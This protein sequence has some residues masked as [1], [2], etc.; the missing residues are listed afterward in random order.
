MLED[1]IGQDYMVDALTFR[2]Q[3]IS[4]FDDYKGLKY[5][6]IKE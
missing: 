4:M 3:T 2:N 5:I 6:D 1:G